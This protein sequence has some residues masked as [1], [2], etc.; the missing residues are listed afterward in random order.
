MSN[1]NS[2]AAELG[3]LRW[4]GV[5]KSERVRAMRDLAKK[6]A[7]KRWKKRRKLYGPN[8]I[9]KSASTENQVSS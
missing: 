1:S 6:T 7:K 9:R 2:A 5:P 4:A 8:G 3:K